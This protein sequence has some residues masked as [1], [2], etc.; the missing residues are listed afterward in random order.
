MGPRVKMDGSESVWLEELI[1]KKLSVWVDRADCV[2][3]VQ[4]AYPFLCR[5]V[6]LCLLR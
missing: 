6:S 2:D 1:A 4:V 5:V 3:L